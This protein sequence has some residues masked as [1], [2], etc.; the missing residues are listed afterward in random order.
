[1][2]AFLLRDINVQPLSLLLSRSRLYIMDLCD[3]VASQMLSTYHSQFPE[4]PRMLTI[5]PPSGTALSK[6]LIMELDGIVFE[7]GQARRNAGK[8][9]PLVYIHYTRTQPK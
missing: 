5:S 6:R 8:S 3:A 9:K 7:I 2:T 1:M 4:V